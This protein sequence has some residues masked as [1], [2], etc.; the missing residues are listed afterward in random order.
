MEIKKLLIKLSNGAFIGNVDTVKEV[1]DEFLGFKTEKDQNNNLYAYKDFGKEKTLLLEAHIDE[2]GFIITDIVDGFLRVEAVGGIDPRMLFGQKVKFFGKKEVKGIFC[3]TPPH[4]KGK[5]DQKFDIKEMAVDTGLKN[6]KE[7]LSLGDFGVFDIECNELLNN[8]ITGKALDNR[9]GC[10]AVL[11][12]FK[13]CENSNYNLALL[14]SSGE[15]LGHRGAI[16]GAFKVNP[17]YAIAVDVSF[18]DCPGVAKHKTSSLGSGAMIGISPI[19]NE[20]VTEGLLNLSNNNGTTEVMG[21]RSGTNADVISISKYGVKTG[22][23]SIPLK[24]MH[25]PVE[26]VEINDILAVSDLIIKFA[27]SEV[28]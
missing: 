24:N 6:A 8:Q 9:A 14:L 21:N 18:G 10:V 16:P 7:F 15:E 4:L 12:A 17:D 13:D 25:T 2:I 19:L 1:V 26:I 3:S 27:E 23:I 28:L 20:T 5:D 22:L 11:K